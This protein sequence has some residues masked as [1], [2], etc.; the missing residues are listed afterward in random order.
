MQDGRWQIKSAEPLSSPINSQTTPAWSYPLQDTQLTTEEAQETLK[1]AQTGLKVL[2]FYSGKID[3]TPGPSTKNAIEAW[4]RQMGH[5]TVGT[6]SNEELEMLSLAAT[7]KQKA[8]LT[9]APISKEKNNDTAQESSVSGKTGLDTYTIILICYIVVSGVLVW[10]YIHPPLAHWYNSQLWIMTGSNPIEI[11]FRQIG[12]RLMWEVFV[13]A[14]ACFLGSIGGN[15]IAFI[16][17]S[18]KA[19]ISATDSSAA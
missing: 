1:T 16:K 8:P 3:G 15:L 11:F 13:F 17:R 6:L 14:M 5:E 12:F 9:E 4:Q 2:G 19:N 7:T 10:P 18:R